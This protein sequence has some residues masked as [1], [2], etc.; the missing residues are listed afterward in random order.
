LTANHGFKLVSIIK[1]RGWKGTVDE[2]LKYW[3]EN[4]RDIDEKVIESVSELRQREVKVHLVSDNE[5]NRAKYL[6]E[7]VG[8]KDKF[9]GAFFSAAL[10]VTKA[11][12]EFYKR[13]IEK[14]QIKPEEITYFDDDEKNVDVAKAVRI[15]ARLYKTA[16][17]LKDL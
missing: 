7:D 1:P 8:L 12:P 14:L 4:E 2:F 10:G 17:D 11:D 15:D 5:I 6:M 13:V 9:D 16:N 3:F